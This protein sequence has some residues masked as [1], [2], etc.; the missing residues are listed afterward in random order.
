[1]MPQVSGSTCT[2][3]LKVSVVHSFR[4]WE[5]RKEES[6]ALCEILMEGFK[7]L[8]LITHCA[9][10]SIPCSHVTFNPHSISPPLKFPH[11]PLK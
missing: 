3:S 9:P 11:I 1:M 7:K 10:E 8:C 4:Y 6:R 5:N 2:I